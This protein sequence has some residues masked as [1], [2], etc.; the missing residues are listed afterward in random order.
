MILTLVELAFYTLISAVA[1]FVL[2]QIIKVHVRWA[3]RDVPYS[4]REHKDRVK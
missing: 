1:G 2:G 3:H 4:I